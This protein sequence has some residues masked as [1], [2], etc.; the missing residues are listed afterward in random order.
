M[1]VANRVPPPL[2]WHIYQNIHYYKSWFFNRFKLINLLF[3]LMDMY[4]LT[5]SQGNDTYICWLINLT[6]MV[7]LI[8]YT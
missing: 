6:I 2:T 8:K 3:L 7:Y 4:I 5:K 1:K